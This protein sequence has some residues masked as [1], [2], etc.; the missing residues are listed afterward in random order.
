M[1]ASAGT[2]VGR[3]SLQQAANYWRRAL[4]AGYPLLVLRALAHRRRDDDA[5]AIQALERALRLAEPERQTE[6]R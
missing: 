3:G 1:P 2:L 5:G 6:C 4:I